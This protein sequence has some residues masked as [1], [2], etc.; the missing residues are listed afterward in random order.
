MADTEVKETNEQA[1][2]LSEKSG[3]TIDDVIDGLIK[4]NEKKPGIIRNKKLLAGIIAAAAAIIYIPGVLHYKDFFSLNTYISEENVSETEI[5]VYVDEYNQKYPDEITLHERDGSEITVPLKGMVTNHDL[6]ELAHNEKNASWLWIFRS[7][8]TKNYNLS[9]ELDLDREAFLNELEGIIKNDER[10]APENAYFD[11]ELLE[12]VPEKDGTMIDSEKLAD[13]IEEALRN[14]KTDLELKEEYVIADITSEDESLQNIVTEMKEFLPSDGI[15]LFLTADV[16]KT[17][18]PD[19]M[20]GWLIYEDGEFSYDNEKIQEYAVKLDA[21]YS[22]DDTK[23]KFVTSGGAAI[24]VG[25][26]AHDNYQG[27]ILNT[28]ETAE[29]ILNAVYD[30]KDTAECVW[31]KTGYSMDE[32]GGDIGGTYIEI[33]IDAQHMWFYKD[34]K[35][36]LDTDVVTGLLSV[37]ER[38]T[39]RGLFCVL[40]MRSPYVMHGSYGS[41]PCEYFIRVTWDGVAIHDADWQSSFGGNIYTYR[42]SHGCI[43]TPHYI[44]DQ[45]WVELDSLD[46]NH[47]PVIIY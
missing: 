28:D 21:K 38:N 35:L 13:S 43:N 44:V 7:F 23:R 45:L 24:E 29:N 8:I 11:S 12:I 25:G 30:G 14:E 46:N 39:P 17:I 36:V 1:T 31:D 33:S 16:K 5:D 37:P 19:E 10:K 15:T 40:E 2:D 6:N 42:G 20:K 34:Y 22:T 9:N 27:Y 3:E 47:V 26:N 32:N 18:T 4:Q 41:Q